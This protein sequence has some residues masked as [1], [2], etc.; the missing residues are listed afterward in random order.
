MKK[1]LYGISALLGLMIVAALIVPG[2]IDWDRYRDQII[3][4][5]SQE[6]GRDLSIDG[7]IS[8][9]I[10]PIPT[11]SVTG[12]RVAN[13]EG[14]GTREMVQLKSLNV[15]V[16]LLPLFAGSIEVAR[17]VLI[18]PDIILERL[19]DGRTNWS[20][21]DPKVVMR[22][23]EGVKTFPQVSLD[24]ISIQNG[25]LTYTDLAKGL[26]ERFEK[27]N[28]TVSAPSLSGPFD[29]F[30]SI[31]FRDIRVE[32]GAGLVE[33][34][35][36]KRIAVKGTLLTEG[37]SLNFAATSDLDRV[38]FIEGRVS[39]NEDGVGSAL[40]FMKQFVEGDFSVAALS[41][42][43]TSLDGK[44]SYHSETLKIDS[45]SLRLGY[46]AGNISGEVSLS[47][48]INFDMTL[49]LG[50]LDLDELSELWPGPKR[51]SLQS[52]EV[53][54]SASRRQSD[55]NSFNLPRN[56]K[57]NLDV[58][59]DAVLYRSQ[60]I[61]DLTVRIGLAGS[62]IDVKEV[63]ALLPG[64]SDVTFF[65]SLGSENGVP[66]FVGQINGGSDNFRALLEWM[67]F[68]VGEVPADRLRRINLSAAIDGTLSSGKVKDIDLYFDATQLRGG[69]DYAIHGSRPGFGIR[70]DLDQL[71]LDAYLPQTTTDSSLSSDKA[72][73]PNDSNDHV[74]AMDPLIPPAVLQAL[75]A[76]DADFNIR[77][78]NL[79]LH[80]TPMSG[81]VLDGLLHQNSLRLRQVSIGDLTGSTI[82]LSG[83]ISELDG[84]PSVD[85]KISFSTEK[86]AT[87]VRVVPLL[88]GLPPVLLG[89]LGVD[90]KFNGSMEMLELE[91]TIAALDS[92][93]KVKGTFTDP[94]EFLRYDVVTQF[95]SPNLGALV[96]SVANSDVMGAANGF[97]LD[98]PISVALDA[99]GDISGLH[100]ESI[101]KF[102]GGEIEV[103]GSVL[104]LLDEP[105]IQLRGVLKH[106]KLYSLVEILGRELDESIP[107]FE[108]PIALE[109]SADGP[110]EELDLE[111]QLTLA[112][113]ALDFEG[114]VQGLPTPLFYESK[115]YMT[116]PDLTTLLVSL[117]LSGPAA[118]MKSPLILVAEVNGTPELLSVPKIDLTV[119]EANIIGSI[120]IEFGGE[121][122]RLTADLRAGDV[123][124]AHF[125]APAVVYGSDK[126][127][128]RAESNPSAPTVG[129][130]DTG[131]RW[132]GRPI[133]LT[134]L[135]ALDANIKLQADSITFFNQKLGNARLALHLDDGY[136]TIEQLSGRIFDGEIELSAK[137]DGRA[138]P[139]VEVSVKLRDGDIQQLF[140]EIAQ[141]DGVTGKIDAEFEISGQ[142]RSQ[143]ELVASLNG[144]G[145][146]KNTS[147]GTIDGI[148]L[149]SL[150]DQINELDDVGDF[151]NLART[152]F[153]GGSSLYTELSGHFSVVNGELQTDDL[154][155]VADGG[156]GD[157]VGV[158]DLAN[159]TQDLAVT[160]T[161]TDHPEIPPIKL[162]LSGSLDKPSQSIQTGEIEKF[163]LERGLRAALRE[164][165]AGGEL[166]VATKVIEGLISK[167]DP[168]NLSD[169]IRGVAEALI[170]QL[171]GVDGSDDR[172]VGSVPGG[173]PVP[174]PI[175]VDKD[176][177]D[178][179]KNLIQELLRE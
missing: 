42:Q 77:L 26:T 67:A 118:A 95:E 82:N 141:I 176:P 16:A 74:V 71:N 139:I 70:L 93:L 132:S 80:G 5:A 1:V 45:A 4:R 157:I 29:V 96:Q 135:G 68:D 163:L 124:V 17:I 102:A 177:E 60:A 37:L 164:T 3:A 11:F 140:S 79:T 107:L 44:F 64:G 106:P 38:P 154:R 134:G 84:V 18:E 109:L 179:F 8:L 145:R 51:G 27:I 81:L 162:N 62:T 2:L 92:Q 161:L 35:S 90:A 147:E 152:S 127:A 63:S 155:V 168:Q 117:G 10:L 169:D 172:E 113:L 111:G 76:F 41:A 30:G 52:N 175:P 34:M 47:A 116:H 53:L 72:L 120:E 160:F 46:V 14:A 101:V 103:A 48:P 9:S 28:L 138:A 170:D 94:L 19:P 166:G 57:G 144:G 121:R 22:S 89:P 87:L 6:L 88:Q 178:P 148:N 54:E 130:A 159:W 142:G 12:I 104:H 108:S 40:A 122:P 85:G 100:F 115:I 25:A 110:L 149:R 129:S 66:H 39:L 50:R 58:T 43:P 21:A 151:I 136:L 33:F 75:L 91:G 112:E 131:K 59:V 78:N 105:E 165:A 114:R 98:G 125:L 23:P 56:L 143:Q 24:E 173:S 55:A 73:I 171:I 99:D 150:S 137:I 128:I 61:R 83:L 97:E 31:N 119:A 123:A 69:V 7:N 36:D 15:Q 86:L 167:G 20:L 32:I 49:A 158:I 153:E 174:L 13:L 133:D 65:G 126:N 146:I 156:V